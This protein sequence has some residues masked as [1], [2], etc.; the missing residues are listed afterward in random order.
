MPPATTN[1][2]F[3][4]NDEPR[5]TNGEAV[6]VATRQRDTVSLR[7][8]AEGSARDGRAPQRVADKQFRIQPHYTTV[9]LRKWA[10]R[11]MNVTPVDT[12]GHERT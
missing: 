2:E 4:R 1:S 11:K 12:S 6:A 10:G 8:D 7:R 5:I 3:R 9:F